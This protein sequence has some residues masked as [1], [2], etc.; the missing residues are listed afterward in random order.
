MIMITPQS[1]PN[2]KHG[3]ILRPQLS[4]CAKVRETG[5]HAYVVT[6]DGSKQCVECGNIKTKE[7]R[8]WQNTQVKPSL[9]NIS[10]GL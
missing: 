10:R 7:R 8:S 1:Q 6:K 5:Q 3:A 9:N 2:F 4:K